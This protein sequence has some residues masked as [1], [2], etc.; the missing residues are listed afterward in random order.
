[1]H[2]IETNMTEHNDIMNELNDRTTQVQEKIKEVESSVTDRL[3]YLE[4]E[5]A[6]ILN[7]ELPSKKKT[8]APDRVDELGRIVALLQKNDAQ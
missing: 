7:D 8:G 2:Q 6:K 1:M 5:Q 4:S 3:D